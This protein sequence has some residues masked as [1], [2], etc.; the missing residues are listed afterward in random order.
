MTPDLYRSSPYF[1]S[2]RNQR[3]WLNAADAFGKDSNGNEVLSAASEQEID[4]V[5][6]IAKDSV[7]GQQIVVE[8]YSNQPSAADEMAPSRLRSLIVAHYLEKHFHLSA[9]NIG[10]MPMNATAPPSSG[11]DSWDG[12][13]IVLLASTASTK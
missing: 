8:G 9:K 11:K 2:L 4:H 6:G 10:L 5:I 13:C 7:I 3:T 12:V 1:N